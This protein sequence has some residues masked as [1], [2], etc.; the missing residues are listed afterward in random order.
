MSWKC[1][2]C[3]SI[4]SDDSIIC[5]VCDSISPFL[6]KF[7]YKYENSNKVVIEWQA[8]NSRKVTALYNSHVYDVST[9]NS[10]RISLQG[11]LTI[12]SIIVSNEATERT[13]TF[14]IPKL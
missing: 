13:Y 3:E 14:G 2:F 12:V 1:G 6:A 5:E 7:N 11:T 8:E 9:W 10:A 4:N